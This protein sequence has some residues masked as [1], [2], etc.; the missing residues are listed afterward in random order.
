MLGVVTSAMSKHRLYTIPDG[1]QRRPYLMQPPL[2]QRV[3]IGG[4][5]ARRLTRPILHTLHFGGRPK[6][7]HLSGLLVRARRIICTPVYVGLRRLRKHARKTGRTA[8]CNVAAFQKNEC[9]R[10][11]LA[12]EFRP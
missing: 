12:R 3:G 2:L 5:A 6:T 9:I 8:A 4:T 1:P 10:G 11:E 7:T